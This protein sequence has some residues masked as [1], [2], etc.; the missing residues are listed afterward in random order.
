MEYTL[1]E[2]EELIKEEMKEWQKL[3]VGDPA[4]VITINMF[5]LDSQNSAL[6]D[7]LV[8]KEII[9]K[10]EHKI[11]SATRTLKSM[12]ELRPEF[13]KFK[14]QLNRDR[15]LVGGKPPLMVIPKGRKH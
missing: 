7:L 5:A 1:A 9:T 10:E 4:E 11:A 2:L 3:G 13:E 6:V 14:Q 15:L 12:R 8:E